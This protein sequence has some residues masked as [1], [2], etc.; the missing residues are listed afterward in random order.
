MTTWDEVGTRYGADKASWH[1]NYLPHYE[2]LMAG[3]KV[4]RML[5][6]G[7]AGG[8]SLALWREVL[9]EAF[10]VGID[11]EPSCLVHQRERSPVVLADATDGAKMW[12]LNTL[13]GPFD[14]IIDDGSHVHED[15]RAAHEGL[16]PRLADGGLYIIEDL[17]PA[18][19][20][21]TRFV[22]RNHGRVIVPES[23]PASR[24]VPSS[25]LVFDKP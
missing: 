18:H 1:H 4:R 6:I 16:Y 10:I 3:R 14:I 9:P 11:I 12:A 2:S 7:V 25:L 21:V 20:W 24:D 23:A 13:Y 5:E 8:R 15:V 17:D 19:E 22:A